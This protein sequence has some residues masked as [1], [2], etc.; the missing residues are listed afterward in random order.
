M[1]KGNLKAVTLLQSNIG[2]IS[3]GLIRKGNLRA[4]TV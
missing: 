1:K 3:G 4:V 2:Y